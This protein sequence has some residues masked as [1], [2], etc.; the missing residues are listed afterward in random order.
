MPQEITETSNN[1]SEYFVAKGFPPRLSPEE[2]TADTLFSV[3]YNCLPE[4][5]ERDIFDEARKIVE[6]KIKA[7]LYEGL[8]GEVP[9]PDPDPDPVS[10][11]VFAEHL[12]DTP[13]TATISL[14]MRVGE[15][16]GEGEY[17]S[18][19]LLHTVHGTRSDYT[20][21]KVTS[22]DDIRPLLSVIQQLESEKSELIEERATLVRV[23]ESLRWERD[24]LLSAY[25]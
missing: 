5:S 22:V 19:N 1:T 24:K 17:A 10:R 4:H 16:E 12:S 7:G 13:G 9:D 23:A 14:E 2:A 11:D 8:P 6:R 18:V 20:V 25:E 3:G 21:D 15:G